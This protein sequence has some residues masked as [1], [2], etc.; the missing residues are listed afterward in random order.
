[1]QFLRGDSWFLKVFCT[2]DFRDTRCDHND[3]RSHADATL[4]SK[5]RL[6][7]RVRPFTAFLFPAQYGLCHFRIH[8]SPQVSGLTFAKIKQTDAPSTVTNRVE[9]TI[10]EAY[11]QHPKD[12]VNCDDSITIFS[13]NEQIPHITGDSSKLSLAPESTLPAVSSSHSIPQAQSV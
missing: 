8:E 13:S 11:G 5:L 6:L 9:V 2:A 1:M 12:S 3:N 4:S 10:H 7:R